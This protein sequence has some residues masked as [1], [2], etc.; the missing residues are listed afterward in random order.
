MSAFNQQVIEEFRAHGGRV[1]GTFE[2]ADLLLLT[3][4]GARSGREHTTPVVYV[5]D[6]ARLLVFASNGGADRHP[7]WY[8]NVR[9]APR[10]LVE[11]GTPEGT[12]D[13]FEAEAVPAEGAERARLYAEQARRDPAFA[14]YQAGTARTIPVVVLRRVAG[15]A[16]PS[17][18][19]AIAAHL[20]E[21][22]AGLRAELAALR[23]GLAAPAPRPGAA[24]G[25]ALARH[26]LAFCGALHTHHTGED[27][28]FDLFQEQFPQLAEDL[29][30][31]R[32]EHRAVARALTALE[33][34][35]ASDA[36]PEVLRTEVD[37]LADDL[38]AH[39]AHEE[40][41]LLPALRG[42]DAGAGAEAGTGT[43]AETGTGTG[44]VPRGR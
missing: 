1:G 25:P 37:R 41:R 38:E 4:R 36:P 14:A 44:E 26:C 6:G 9:A 22:H 35:L 16:D 21:V 28:V 40:A 33:A 5:R 10:V 8:H 20:V 18:H 12:L 30:R 42:T 19:A 31:M 15:I 24:L 27:G 39:F 13:R 29:D 43:R 11:V 3:T 2:G 32:E 17:R 34:L 23:E 7:A